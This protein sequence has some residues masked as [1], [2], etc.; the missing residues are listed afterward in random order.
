MTA[1]AADLA[2]LRRAVE[3]V[4]DRLGRDSRTKAAIEQILT[5]RS[6]A[7]SPPQAST[8]SGASSTTSAVGRA[9]PIDGVYHVHTTPQDLRAIGT[10][11]ADI[12]PEN[13]GEYKMVLNRGHFTQKQPLGGTA[14]GTYAVNADTLTLTFEETAGKGKNKPGE[15]FTFR[16]SL[17]R[18]QLTFTAVPGKISPEPLRAKPWRR[19][20]DTP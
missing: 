13:Y 12:F 15:Q 9:T 18:D 3:P 20:G 8:C 11:E 19:I 6:A 17:Y 16:W 1:S 5:M 10:P 2:S 4:Y 7:H 14:A